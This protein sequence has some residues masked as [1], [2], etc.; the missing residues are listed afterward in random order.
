MTPQ[1]KIYGCVCDSSWDVGLA[2]GERQQPEFFSPDCSLK[3][4]PT[5]DDPGTPTIDERD[6]SGKLA[7]GGKGTGAPGN[8]CHIDCSG[9]GNCDYTT[10]LCTCHEGYHGDNCG[11]INE[12]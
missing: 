11:T 2:S 6:C 12:I 9:R 3:R 5:G 7:Y 4:C 1:D 10:G 8:L